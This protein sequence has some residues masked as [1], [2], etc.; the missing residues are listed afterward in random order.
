MS[1]SL[2]LHFGYNKTDG[3]SFLILGSKECFG[4]PKNLTQRVREALQKE[5]PDSEKASGKV[6]NDRSSSTKETE[7][8]SVKK[9]DKV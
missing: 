6:K 9:R 1:A 3:N 7:D 5:R 2:I 4:E 8:E